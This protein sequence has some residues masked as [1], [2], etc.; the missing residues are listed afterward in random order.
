M[1][2]GESESDHDVDHD[3]VEDDE[4]EDEE[5]LHGALNLDNV[6][7]VS[8]IKADFSSHEGEQLE[9]EVVRI[10]KGCPARPVLWESWVEAQ[11]EANENREEN[12]DELEDIL[13]D[14]E[15]HLNMEWGIWKVMEDSHDEDPWWQNHPGCDVNY[16]D[17]FNL[18]QATDEV[19]NE[20]KKM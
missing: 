8:C 10:N 7:Q 18:A 16:W 5:D 6:I 19:D 17:V 1:Q 9:D 11:G 13:E 14:V 2:R 12:E 20:E 15:K 4:D 3:N